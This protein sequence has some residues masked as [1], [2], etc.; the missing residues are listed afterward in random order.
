MPRYLVKTPVEHD[1]KPYAPGEVVVL[2]RAQ[3]AAMPD[4]VEAAP[5]EAPAAP[6]APPKQPDKGD[7][8]KQSQ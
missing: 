3:A 2:T 4:A 5:P 8:T 6:P 7:A 1:G